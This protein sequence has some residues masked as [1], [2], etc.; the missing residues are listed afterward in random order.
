[1]CMLK[2]SVL[3][4][5]CGLI[6]LSNAACFNAKLEFGATHCQDLADKTWH[7]V[8]SAWTNSKCNKCECNPTSLRC[9]DGLPSKL[10]FSG[11]CEV[12]YNYETCTFKVFQKGNPAIE[13]PYSATGK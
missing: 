7:P 3:V 10:H 12:K 8:G 13:C 5:L 4:V 2:W 9:C 11:D 1:M 6:P